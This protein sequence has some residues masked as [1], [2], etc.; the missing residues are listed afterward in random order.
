MCGIV[1]YIGKKSSKNILL[2]GL[3]KLEYRGYDS[4]GIATISNNKFEI[5][6]ST[7]RISDLEKISKESSFSTIGIGHTRWATHGAPS[8]QN[9]H[10]HVDFKNQFAVVHNGI[11]ENYMELKNKLLKEGYEFYSET[12]TEIIPNLIS[13]HYSGDVKQAIQKAMK[14]IKGSFA[15]V[16]MESSNLET[17]YVARRK[18]PLLIG[19]SENGKIVASDF[20]AIAEYTNKVYLL[21]NDEIA[22]LT[23]EKVNIYDNKLNLIEKEVISIDLDKQE[24]ELGTFKH[25]MQKEIYENPVSV[26][27]TLEKYFD[28]N[29][30]IQLG[31]SEDL[32]EN[33]TGITIVACGTA[34]HAGLTAKYNIEELI[35]IPVRV[36]VASEFKYRR[37]ILNENDLVIFISQSG[38]TADTLA[39][40]E[41]VKEQNIKHISIVNVPNSTLARVSDNVLYTQAGAEIAVAST[42]AYIAQVTLLNILMLELAK[43]QNAISKEMQKQLVDELFLIPTDIETILEEQLIYQ[44]YAKLIRD[45]KSMFFIGRGMDYY[46]VLEGSLKLKEI[47]YIHSEAYQAGELKHGTISLIEKGTSV[48]AVCTNKELVEKTMSNIKEVTSRG[49][50]VLY[51]TNLTEEQ[52]ETNLNDEVK[53]IIQ[54]PKT[55]HYF[56]PLLS[57]VPMQLIAYYTTVEKGLD[58]DKPR[59]LAKSVTVE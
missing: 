27:K 43:K 10:P 4:C 13:Y 44:N 12:D 23:N 20:S 3:K 42:K 29:R 16:I 49:A 1:G 25:Y 47:S 32:L 37:M 22:E 58:V 14:E 26:R 39:A 34:M 24:L 35:G 51:I 50:E 11:I 33:I 59:N 7:K 2:S 31:L 15:L 52:N 54:I 6:K 28:E 53:N 5:L 19:I 17:L 40:Q 45:K 8:E 38:E 21:E 57:V 30:Q 9:S 46:S 55:N 18:S 36:D 41:L 56:S 48:I